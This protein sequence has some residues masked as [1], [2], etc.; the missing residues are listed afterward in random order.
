[1]ARKNTLFIIS[2]LL[3]LILSLSVATAI[4]GRMGN[5]KM[6]LRPEVNGW[7]NT[8]IEKSILVKNVNDVPI[9]V[10]LEVSEDSK[11][12]IELIDDFFYMEPNTEETATVLIT[13]LHQPEVPAVHIHRQ[14]L[15]QTLDDSRHLPLQLI[16]APVGYG[17]TTL[18]SCWISHIDT[19]ICQ[20]IK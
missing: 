5:A 16:V 17:K 7:T 19:L 1:M 20:Q 12:F 10:T 11:D 3:I 18:I 13:K 14:R 15:V 4:S 9:N 8:I 2:I 6:V